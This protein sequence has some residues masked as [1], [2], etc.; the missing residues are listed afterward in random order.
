MNPPGRFLEFDETRSRW[1]D[2]PV[3]QVID[4]TCQALLSSGSDVQ[5]TDAPDSGLDLNAPWVIEAIAKVEKPLN[6]KYPMGSAIGIKL[7]NRD[8]LRSLN[9][10]DPNI[11]GPPRLPSE[12]GPVIASPHI[13]DV[14]F[15]RGPA[16]SAHPA[17]RR[18]RRIIWENREEYACMPRYVGDVPL[19]L[20][21]LFRWL[22]DPPLLMCFA[23]TKRR[24]SHSTSSTPFGTWSHLD[25]SLSSTR[26]TASGMRFPCHV[27]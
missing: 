11:P 6:S 5:W 15:G 17:N 20:F 24:R 14:L 25:D 18:F 23:V 13:H 2:A 4:A 8:A 19:V 10:P 26:K 21:V 9:L 7:P 22:T 1:K 12:E 3:A 27:L 16:C